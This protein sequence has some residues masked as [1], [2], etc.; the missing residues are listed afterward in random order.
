MIGLYPVERKKKQSLI[1]DIEYE[2]E[3]EINLVSEN[4][5]SIV[6]YHDLSR[7]LVKQAQQ[8]KYLLLETLAQA[9]M[10]TLFEYQKISYAKVTIKKPRA[11]KPALVSVVFEKT[12]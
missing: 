4:A 12:R 9:L 3:P 7:L 8:S 1:L 2:Y 11:L 6:D 5:T 10:N